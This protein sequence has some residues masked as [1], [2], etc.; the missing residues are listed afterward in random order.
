MSKKQRFKVIISDLDGT[1]LN[2]QHRISDYSKTIFRKLQAENYI[3]IIA[4]GRHHLDASRIVEGLGFPVYLVTSNGARIHSPS[5]ELI[6]AFDMD[7]DAVKSILNLDYDTE[8]TTVLYKENYWLTDKEDEFLKSDPNLI[9]YPFKIV[10]F[11]SIEDLGAIKLFF[12][13]ENQQKL[14][15][16]RNIL[17]EEHLDKFNHAFSTPRSLEIMDKSVD[18]SIAISKILE[19]E[20][21]SFAHCI[22][23]GDGFNDE[24]MLHAAGKGLIMENAAESLKNKLSHLEVII[25]NHN[26]GV[27]KYLSELLLV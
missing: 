11:E 14:I 17:V 19:N 18:K 9:N 22:V 23:F 1:L 3:I 8:I 12:T 25:S 24:N 5:K 26:D 4:T 21:L 27:A 15:H 16:L 20:K 6:Y 13:H 2:K 7:S 10:D